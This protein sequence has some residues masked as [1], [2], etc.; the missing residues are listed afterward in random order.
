MS[1]ILYP[2]PPNRMARILVGTC[3]KKPLPVVR[4]Y[5]QALQW[6]DRPPN[7]ELS[8]AF[9]DDSG[10]PGVHDLLASA[11]ATLL[12]PD[13]DSAPYD[14]TGPVTHQWSPAAMARVGRMKNRLLQKA[15]TEKYDA[16]WLVDADLICD[17]TTFRSLWTLN[18]PIACAVYWTYWN[19]PAAMR[20]Q[21]HAAPQVWLQ[22]PYGLEGRGMDQAE[23]RARLVTRQRTEVWGQG[24]CT[25]IRTPVIEKGVNFD[26]VP[27]V[28]LEGM[29]AGEDRHFCLRAESLHIPMFADPWPDLFHIY[30]PTDQQRI[31]EMLARLGEEHPTRPE[32]G[33]QVSLLLE[34]IEPVLV[35]PN[36][37]AQVPPQ[38]VRGRIGGLAML[39]ELENQIVQMDRGETAIVGVHFPA[40]HP[41]PYLRTQRRLIRVT[42]ID[43]KR[44]GYAPVV[45]DELLQGIL[46]M[47]DRTTLTEAQQV[48]MQDD[49]KVAA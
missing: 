19:N 49:A 14:D 7:T 39:P 31:P 21:L 20:G 11:N 32:F 34:A 2:T 18:V 12:A 17:T 6:Q 27:G 36:Q 29:M 30:H 40:H 44:M 24:A 33:D 10:D 38:H 23:F 48:A 13:Q 8:F 37:M 15:V 47:A 4:A 25:L 5:L 3:I 1:L 22:H 42:L 46:G 9:V 41:M 26:Y 45:E 28:P 16:I 43:V 35:G